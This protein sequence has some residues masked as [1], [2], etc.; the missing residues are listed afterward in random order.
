MNRGR[1]EFDTV[2]NMSTS[3]VPQTLKIR[4]TIS[5]CRDHSV[6]IGWFRRDRWSAITSDSLG[7]ALL[8]LLCSEPL[9]RGEARLSNVTRWGNGSLLVC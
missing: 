3:G 2:A 4:L 7:Y 1:W 5:G 6:A 9:T 8:R